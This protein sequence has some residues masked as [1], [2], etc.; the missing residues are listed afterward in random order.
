[1]KVRIVLAEKGIEYESREISFA[2]EEQ[3]S[4][5]YLAIN[6]NGVVPSLVHDGE[7]VIDSSCIMEYLDEVVPSPPLSPPTALG[8]GRM[9]SWLRYF[10]EVPT[11]AVRVPS[12]QEVFLPLL[13]MIRNEEQFD[14][15]ASR[16]P[17]RQGFYRKMNSGRGFSADEVQTSM[18]QLQQ[19]VDRI[20]RASSTGPW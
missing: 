6:P 7:P 2:S 20:E 5:E 14:E 10:E 9:R 15:G 19:T 17:I 3:L 4:P 18:T 12:F 1:Q 13:R 8:R 11:A 16:R